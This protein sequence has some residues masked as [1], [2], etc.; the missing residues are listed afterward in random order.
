[1]RHVNF[2]LLEL[3]HFVNKHATLDANYAWFPR[4]DERFAAQRGTPITLF[5]AYLLNADD[6]SKVRRPNRMTLHTYTCSS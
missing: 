6:L 5:F 4:A 2:S 3:F 1:M